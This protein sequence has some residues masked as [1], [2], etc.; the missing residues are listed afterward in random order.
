MRPRV[1]GLESHMLVFCLCLKKHVGKEASYN[2]GH[3]TIVQQV[4]QQRWI[5][6]IHHSQATKHTSMGIHPKQGISG[7]NWN[8]VLLFFKALIVW[9]T[10]GGG[11]E[12]SDVHMSSVVLLLVL[13]FKLYGYGTNKALHFFYLM[14]NE[15]TA[16]ITHISLHLIV[17]GQQL[18]RQF[19]FNKVQ[20]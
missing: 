5:W 18:G 1:L 12:K 16:D 4:S 13:N 11:A 9:L 8:N 7:H 10:Q 19:I 6:K 20:Q 3:T 14:F 2:V 15:T 17:C